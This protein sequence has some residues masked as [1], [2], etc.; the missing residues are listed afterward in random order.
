MH[1]YS[2]QENFDLGGKNWNVFFCDFSM[3]IYL[4]D[5]DRIV[6]SL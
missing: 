4:L 3:R 6:D 5:S 1:Q 2:H